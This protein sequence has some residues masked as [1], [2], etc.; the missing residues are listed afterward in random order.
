M[1]HK[2][3]GATDEQERLIEEI[4]D[5]HGNVVRGI[6]GVHPLKNTGFELMPNLLNGIKSKLSQSTM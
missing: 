6:D 5:E 1:I 2:L 3:K 4:K